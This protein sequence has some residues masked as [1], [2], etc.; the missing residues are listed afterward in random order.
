MDMH[1]RTVVSSSE[2]V[3]NSDETPTQS[4][5]YR[6]LEEPISLQSI[7]LSLNEEDIHCHWPKPLP[8]KKARNQLLVVVI[9][10]LCFMV[11]EILGGLLSGSLALLTDATHLASDIAGLLISL[12]SLWMA[13]KPASAKLSFGFY[14]AEVIGALCSILIIWILTGVLCYLAVERI[15]DNSFEIEAN[16]MLITAS[17]GVFFN[18]VMGAVL[19]LASCCK[20]SI[21]HGHSH[22]HTNEHHSHSADDKNQV[23]INVRAAFIHII[24]DFIQ[25]IGVLIAAIV[26]KIKPDYKLADPICTFLFSVLVIATTLTVIRDVLLVFM[27]AVP[28]GIDYHTIK[29]SLQSLPDVRTVHSLHVWA[30]TMDK[31]VVSVHL[32]TE[33]DRATDWNVLVKRASKLLRDNHG[34]FTTN[35]QVELFQEH[36]MSLCTQCK[37][38]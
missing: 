12:F 32:A 37:L 4:N 33:S 6:R 3:S 10:S 27:E 28:R 30:L 5:A 18:I 29:E 35:I 34:A 38:P 22:A 8:N 23:N 11:V 15:V 16:G 36:A 20:C 26:I 19:H 13:K 31:M 24:G 25:S 21:P 1:D 14:R 7:S 2:N 17:L 9:L